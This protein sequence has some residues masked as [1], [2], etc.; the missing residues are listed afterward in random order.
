[1]TPPLA[2]G[3][4]RREPRGRYRRQV[5]GEREG[6]LERGLH[7]HQSPR[8]RQGRRAAR[9]NVGIQRVGVGVG[10]R[11]M[12]PDRA[13]L[14]VLEVGE[15]R[16]RA[17]ERRHARE[18]LFGNHGGGGKVAALGVVFQK[19]IQ[20]VDVRPPA[21]GAHTRSCRPWARHHRRTAL[22]SWHAIIA[23]MMGE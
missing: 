4:V 22:S 14:R 13:A 20:E 10:V 12:K 6:G 7:L 1:M 18:R 17:R 23:N 3:E 11:R 8:R 16:D 2:D 19:R 21:R 5:V 15:R 9:H